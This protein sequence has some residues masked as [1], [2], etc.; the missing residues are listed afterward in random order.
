MRRTQTLSHLPSYPLLAHSPHTNSALTKFC[1]SCCLQ[2]N[3]LGYS[4]VK[5]L[6]EKILKLSSNA[7]I[8][9]QN[10]QDI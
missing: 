10:L 6:N 8:I 1:C 3:I 5:I 2:V 9:G 7:V 4:F